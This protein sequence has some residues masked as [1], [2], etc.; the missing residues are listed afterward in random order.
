MELN[1]LI[2]Q[3]LSS[4]ILENQELGAT[5]LNSPD[6]SKE[7][8]KVYVD[9][10]VREYTEGKVNFF[11]EEHKNLFRIWTELYLETVKDDIKNRVKK[12]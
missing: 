8:K 2:N 1:Q 5:L 3:L 11:S 6:L 9:N 12:I 7:E 4:G 10:F